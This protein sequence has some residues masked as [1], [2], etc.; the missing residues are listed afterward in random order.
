[1]NHDI[2]A[3]LGR[4]IELIKSETPDVQLELEL[5][6]LHPIIC[7]VTERLMPAIHG[8]SQKLVTNLTPELPSIRADYLR[9]EQI[10]LNLLSHASRNTPPGDRISL[11]AN[12][13]DDFVLIDI[14]YG[15]PAIP[16]ERQ[17]HMSQPLREPKHDDTGDAWDEDLSFALCKYFVELHGGV[18]QAKR[19][20]NE[21]NAFSIFFPCK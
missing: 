6:N 16:P 5:L 17:Y 11:S 8:K 10:L 4:F 3:K 9:V 2:E 21:A 13:Q 14:H 7:A 18:I 20:E 19:E 15:R 12:Q 1:M